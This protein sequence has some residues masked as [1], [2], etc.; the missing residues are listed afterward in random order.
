MTRRTLT[1]E[2]A[3]LTI[4]SSAGVHEYDRC[5]AEIDIDEQRFSSGQYEQRSVNIDGEINF[6]HPFPFDTYFDHQDLPMVFG[7]EI[8]D[9][10]RCLELDQVAING[11]NDG[12]DQIEIVACG[13][14]LELYEQEHAEMLSREE[15]LPV[16]AALVNGDYETVYDFFAKYGPERGQELLKN[17]AERCDRD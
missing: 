10:E 6:P 12:G 4:E 17:T 2:D 3:Q 13:W 9:G 11:G 5:S 16:A 8:E 14:E 15:F 7:L 1:F